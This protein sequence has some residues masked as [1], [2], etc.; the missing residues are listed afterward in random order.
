MSVKSNSKR[1]IFVVDPDKDFCESVRLYL[2]DSYN[3]NSRQG[4]EYVDYTILLKKIDL[5]LIDADYVS[6]NLIGVLSDVRKKHNNLKIIIM[7][8]YFASNKKDEVLLAKAADDMI[9]K[10]FDVQIL[11]EKLESLL[12][13]TV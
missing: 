5:L 10:P 11:K 7:Y 3:V 1:N 9:A 6:Q 12:L 8:T 13:L 4:L 2:E